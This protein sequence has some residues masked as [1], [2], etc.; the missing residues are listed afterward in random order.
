VCLRVNGLYNRV[1][2]MAEEEEEEKEE[3][4]DNKRDEELFG[5]V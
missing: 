3:K 1:E 2:W 4:R 5:R